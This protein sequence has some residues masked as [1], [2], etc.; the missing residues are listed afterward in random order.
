MLGAA[1]TFIDAADIPL[2]AEYSV[3]RAVLVVPGAKAGRA[4]G[5]N[6]QVSPI[7]NFFLASVFL[8]WRRNRD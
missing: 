4:H 7:G 3:V 8:F 2:A 6:H 1:S 5:E